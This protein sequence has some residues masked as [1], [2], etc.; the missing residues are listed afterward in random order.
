MLIYLFFGFVGGIPADHNNIFSLFVVYK[1]NLLSF[2]G[3]FPFYCSISVTP[4]THHTLN[5]H[6]IRIY[7]YM[8]LI[9]V[10]VAT[11]LI[12]KQFLYN[13]CVPTS[14]SQSRLRYHTCNIFLCFFLTFS[15]SPVDRFSLH[16]RSIHECTKKQSLTRPWI[17]K[18][19]HLIFFYIKDCS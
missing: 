12:K 3:F 7:T 2:I 1:S 9:F 17:Y 16:T 14:S 4:F 10:L 15:L 19:C 11:Y 5:I 6:I 18:G 8:G 13:N